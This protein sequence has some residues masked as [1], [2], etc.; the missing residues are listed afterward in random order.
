MIVR[1]WLQGG[2]C[3]LNLSGGK[4]SMPIEMLNSVFV[5]SFATVW[6]L[7]GHFTILQK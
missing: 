7:I 1:F 2:I 5:V 6:V 4:R 3:Y